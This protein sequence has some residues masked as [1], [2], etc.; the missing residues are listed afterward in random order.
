[1]NQVDEIEKIADV[2][3]GKNI[4][5]KYFNKKMIIIIS[6]KKKLIIAL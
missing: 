1:M 4:L 2:K 6:G 3:P 5:L